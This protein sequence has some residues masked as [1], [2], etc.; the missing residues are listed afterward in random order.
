[1]SAHGTYRYSRKKGQT[2]KA[3]AGSSTDLT[4]SW[5]LPVSPWTVVAVVTEELSNM[6]HNQGHGEIHGGYMGGCHMPPDKETSRKAGWGLENRRLPVD[7]KS[8]FSDC[9]DFPL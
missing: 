1:M 3:G 5:F 6:K 4:H 2:S 7:E 9:P 8:L